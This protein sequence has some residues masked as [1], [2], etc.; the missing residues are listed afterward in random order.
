MQRDVAEVVT[1]D[2]HA[3]PAFARGG[4]VEAPDHERHGRLAAPARADQGHPLPRRDVQV[5]P[6][7][8]RRPVP[9]AEATRRRSRWPPSRA[10]LDRVGR[11]GDRGLQVEQ[12][13][14]PLDPGPGLL[15][16]GQD[17]G[18]L[19][20]RGD[21]L[22][23]V[24]REGEERPDRHLVPEGQPPAEGEDRHLGQRRDRLHDSGW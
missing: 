13:E 17:A 10:E 24:G 3:T 15:A 8:H 2:P 7:E 4:L 11:V 18:E 16:H 19:P 23:N 22:G 20:G 9:I 6:V 14:D 1:V 21:E 5:E 12:L